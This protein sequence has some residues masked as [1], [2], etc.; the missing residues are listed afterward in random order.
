MNNLSENEIRVT[1]IAFDEF[2]KQK[3][4]TNLNIQFELEQISP[5][6]TELKRQRDNLR[7]KQAEKLGTLW[8]WLT[9]N[10]KK[11]IEFEIFKK[12]IEQFAERKMFDDY[13]YVFEQ[14]GKTE[15]E[16]GKGFHAHL[17]LKRN[18]KYKQNKIISNSKN[19]FKNL[20]NVENNEIFNYHWCP[21]E[22]LDDKIEYM[23]GEKTGCEKDIKQLIDVLFR[24]KKNL[25]NYYKKE[26]HEN[27]TSASTEK[28]VDINEVLK[29]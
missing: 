10:P 22:Y 25:N 28:T 24:E 3:I 18:M 6:C 11:D 4:K 16:A 15:E 21:A 12:K 2:L 5:Y 1:K 26:C 17:L 13:L 8:L 27:K 20:T 29:Q 7:Q 19:T 23:T 14:R 9:I